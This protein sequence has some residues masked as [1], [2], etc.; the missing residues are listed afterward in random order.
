M[1]I[2]DSAYWSRGH[3]G[4]SALHVHTQQGMARSYQEECSYL[5]Q[6]SPCSFRIKKGFVPN[7]NVSWI[8]D[9]KH[10]TGTVVWRRG[11]FESVSPIHVTTRTSLAAIDCDLLSSLPGLYMSYTQDLNCGCPQAIWLAMICFGLCNVQLSGYIHGLI[12]AYVSPFS[13]LRSFSGLYTVHVVLNSVL[14]T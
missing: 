7:M 14:E 12:D 6:M 9:D 1:C 11:E 8:I 3:R 5:E 4:T 10:G 2:R 13:F